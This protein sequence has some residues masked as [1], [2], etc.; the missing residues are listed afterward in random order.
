MLSVSSVS[1]KIPQQ[2]NYLIFDLDKWLNYHPLISIV[3]AHNPTP[4][5]S[6]DLLKQGLADQ[7]R[8]EI[9]SGSLVP[10]ERIVERAWAQKYGVAQASIREAINILEKDGFV[11]K[12]PGQTAQV[13]SLS[14]VDIAQ[15]YEVRAA[16]EG[17]AARLAAS[18]RPD[19][20]TLMSLVS[21]MQNAV[22][23]DDADRLVECDL[24]FHVEL[25]RLA[26][27]R[28]LQ[29][30]A[31]RI[32][33]P[34]FAFFRLRLTASDGGLSTWHKDVE[35]HKKIV[36]LIADGEADLAEHYVRRSMERF[37]QTAHKN[38]MP[39]P[40]DPTGVSEERLRPGGA[41]FS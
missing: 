20:T 25:C 15:L 4:T 40:N 13:I 38:W 19:V 31:V 21:G 37:A 8:A 7:L 32:L 27:N 28:H 41:V 39:I 23:S 14:D 30:H 17:M 22:A 33:R 11:T 3:S 29:E 10:G 9:V 1:G 5:R 18:A 6:D 35:A 36:D 2:K 16:L 34:F 12:R 24:N 26:G